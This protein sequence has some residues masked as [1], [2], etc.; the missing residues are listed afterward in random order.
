MKVTGNEEILRNMVSDK[1]SQPVERPAED[2]NAI[3]KEKIET[4]CEPATPGIAEFPN[5][6]PAIRGVSGIETLMP[7]DK[8]TTVARVENLLDLLDDYRQKLVNPQVSLKQ[9]E[10]LVDRISMEKENLRPTLKSMHEGEQLQGILNQTLV[11]ASLEVIKFK[12]GDYLD[13]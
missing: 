13:S 7:L 8:T 10:A 9:M 11:A 4:A 2:F 12:R 1:H 6:I 3:L 5:P